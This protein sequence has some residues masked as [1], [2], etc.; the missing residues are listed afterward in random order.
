MLTSA[1]VKKLAHAVG[2]DLCGITTAE[3]ITEAI[4]QFDRWLLLDYHGEMNYLPQ[5][6]DHR[7][8]PSLLLPGAR[9]VIMLGLNYFQRDHDEPSPPKPGQFVDRRKLPPR[10]FA[11]AGQGRVS[12][13]ARGR[14]YHKVVNRMTK[15]LVNKLRDYPNVSA[16]HQFYHWVDYGPFLERAYAERAGLGY[17]GRNAMLINRDLGSWFFL[18]EVLTTVE[19]EP[20]DPNAINHGICGSC[21]RCIEAC[22]TDAIVDD[23]VVDSRRCISYLT[24]ER[25]S[26]I[27][28]ELHKPMGDYVFGCD[29]CQDV[30]PHNLKAKL[31]PHAEM[32]PDAG[33]GELLD[34][35]DLLALEDRDQFLDLTA[36]TPLVRPKREGLQRNAGIVKNNQENH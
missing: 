6:R 16:D 18:G 3:P 26:M 36:G 32:L 12:K 4:N 24:I 25:P 20:D 29:I 13:Y 5:R 22:P 27:P 9:S 17:I 1:V 31:T 33:V 2:F 23:G 7:A 10:R 28:D 8:E 15:H 21:R 11:P 30:C 34:L 14:D 19:L 35:D